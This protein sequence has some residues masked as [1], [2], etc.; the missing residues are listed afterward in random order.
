MEIEQK[1][2]TDLENVHKWLISNKLTLNVEKTEYMIIGSRNRL[3]QIHSNPEIVIGEQTIERVARKEFLGVIVNEKLNW[4]EQIDTQCKKISK[5]I[6][7]L[8]RAKNYITTDALVIMYNAFVL[9]HFTYCSTVW[10]QGNVTHMVSFTNYKK[11]QHELLLA[12][13]TKLE[14]LTSSK[15]CIGNQLKIFLTDANN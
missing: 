4:H 12:Q 7:L 3:N 8:R 10:Q 13:A 14:V 1:L 11:G 6:A 15:P 9:P 2:N 5:N